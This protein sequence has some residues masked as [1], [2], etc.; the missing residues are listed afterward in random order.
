MIKNYSSRDLT[1]RKASAND[2]HSIQVV[3]SHARKFMREHGNPHQW[4]DGKPYPYVIEKDINAGDCYVVIAEGKIRAVFSLIP[5]PDSTYRVIREGEWK[6]RRPYI[7]L[8]RAAS[9]GTV[10][11]IV[12]TAVEYC[13]KEYPDFQDIRADTHKSNIVMQKA[14][15]KA[16]FEQCGI[17]RIENGD[18]RI[19]FHLDLANL[20]TSESACG[21]AKSEFV[22]KDS[23]GK[24]LSD[25]AQT[26]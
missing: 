1:I 5:G 18:K 26:K 11:G 12:K 20:K 6:N 24:D 23:A 9:D 14:M 19:G 10:H 7:A 4:G 22:R 25:F 21:S 15:K 13:E 2:I 3:F 16:G 8:H 17:I